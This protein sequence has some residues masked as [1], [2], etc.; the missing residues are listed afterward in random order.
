[1]PKSRIYALGGGMFVLI[2][3]GAVVRHDILPRI[4]VFLMAIGCE[5]RA[6]AEWK[7]EHA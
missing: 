6:H 1:M 3:I 4:F 2:G 7:R 5:V